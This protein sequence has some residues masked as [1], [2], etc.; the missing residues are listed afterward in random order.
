VLIEYN[1]RIN[2]DGI[3]ELEKKIIEQ[4][5]GKKIRIQVDS[6]ESDKTNRYPSLIQ[7]LESSPKAFGS[8]D[9]ITRDWIYEE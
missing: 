4:L 8:N 5:R 2:A 1:T 6:E 9:N 3:L 7:S